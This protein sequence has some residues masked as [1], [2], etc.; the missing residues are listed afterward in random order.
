MSKRNEHQQAF[1]GIPSEGG[2]PPQAQ[3][4]A[5]LTRVLDAVAPTR[6]PLQSSGGALKRAEEIGRAHLREKPAR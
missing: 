2:T 1:A 5:A 6:R 4:E 3:V